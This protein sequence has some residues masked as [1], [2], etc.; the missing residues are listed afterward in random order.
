MASHFEFG[1]TTSEQAGFCPERLARIMP[2]FGAAAS[3]GKLP[4]AVALIA[5]KGQLV[6]HEATGLRDPATQDPM[7]L[8][9]LFRI[10]SMTKP[11]VSVA[12]MMMVEQGKLLLSDKVAKFFP[13]FEDVQVETH[14]NGHAM[15]NKPRC[16]PTIHDLLRHTAGL[17]YE[18]LGTE[19]IQRMYAQADL[20]SRSRTS[21]EFIAAIANMPLMF[22]PA[23]TFEYSRATDVLGALVEVISGESLGDFLQA[24][25]LGPLQ[26]NDTAFAVAP[27]HHHRIAE[28]FAQ[29]PES[30]AA[31]QL[32]DVTKPY[33]LESGG[34]GLVSTAM[35]YARFL[36]CL[37]QGG[38]LGG[39]RILSPNT[40][41]FMTSDHLGQ[42]AQHFTQRSGYMLPPGVGF[43]LGFSVKLADGMESLPGCTGLYSW[44]GI[45]GTVFFV[46]PEK[47][48]FAILMTQAPNQR[49]FY[50][51][52]FRNMVYA[53]LLE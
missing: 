24:N 51:P 36:Q 15:L 40:V 31:V 42:M 47:E 22:E 13:E 23:T 25:V 5:R 53:A 6:L 2:V 32:I 43:G 35:D 46:D 49:D 8:D 17:T 26:M 14:V 41:R 33:P 52:L 28:P 20:W 18:T 7:T 12:V 1:Q 4:G 30:G 48:M 11:L 39:H 34:L 16:A 44:G 10:Y 3:D 27:K 19:P 9:S 45:A 50:R 21:R 29:D 38:M 37:L